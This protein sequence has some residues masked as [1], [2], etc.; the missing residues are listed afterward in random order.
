MTEPTNAEKNRVVAERWLGWEPD[1]G[2]HAGEDSWA[3]HRGLVSPETRSKFACSECAFGNAWIDIPND[4]VA[5]D[6]LIQA[7]PTCLVIRGTSKTRVSVGGYVADAATPANWKLA[8]RDAA[9]EAAM[10]ERSE[11]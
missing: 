9:W 4:P 1:A 8:L 7:L 10:A 2:G 6:A 3:W 5:A 11:G